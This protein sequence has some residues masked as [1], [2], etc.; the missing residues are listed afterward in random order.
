MT[1]VDRATALP[2]GTVVF[3]RT[4]IEGS[5]ELVRAL[6][7]RYDERNEQHRGIVRAAIEGNGGQ[8]VRTEGDAFMAAFTVAQEAAKAAVEI[9]AEMAK[10]PWPDGHPFRTRV[11]IHAGSAYR[12]GDDYGGFEVNRSARIAAMGWGGQIVV[13]DAVRALIR[14]DLEDGW[15]LRDLGQ[16]RLRGGAGTRAALAA[17]RDRDRWGLPGTPKRHG[18]R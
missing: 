17:R 12:A 1:A 6:G 4:D 9:Q 3:M 10:Q 11:G 13:S 2:T 8:V 18:S 15:T 5:M 14:D 16:H 7:T